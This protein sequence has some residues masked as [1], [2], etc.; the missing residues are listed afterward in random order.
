MNEWGNDKREVNNNIDLIRSHPARHTWTHTTHSCLSFFF[1]IFF[2]LF[3]SH[4][5][6]IFSFA[7]SFS[8]PL[9][10]P[11]RCCPHVNSIR[12]FRSSMW[13]RE[14]HHHL[15]NIL[16]IIECP[17]WND[18]QLGTQE[19]HWNSTQ[20][21]AANGWILQREAKVRTEYARSHVQR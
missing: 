15:I 7:R 1:F 3:P 16:I 11:H 17:M 5:Y 13:I 19:N 2:S 8:S 6:W 20:Y 4:I 18:M 10:R 9:S 21:T 12:I 14:T